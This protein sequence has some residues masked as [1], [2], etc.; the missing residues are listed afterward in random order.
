MKVLEGRG[1]ERAEVWEIKSQ[2]MKKKK[3]K[4]TNKKS[5]G[6]AVW[7]NLAIVSEVVSGGSE[8]RGVSE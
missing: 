5:G 7:R 8:S 4:K 3:K 6:V 2:K 1:V